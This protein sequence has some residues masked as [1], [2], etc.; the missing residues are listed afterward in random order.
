MKIK[1]FGVE[2]VLSGEEAQA[3]LKREQLVEQLLLANPEAD[4]K[5]EEKSKMV[6]RQMVD[7]ISKLLGN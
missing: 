4:A 1:A 3:F 2:L 5:L 7:G 6:A